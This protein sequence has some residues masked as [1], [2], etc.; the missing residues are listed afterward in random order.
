M[1]DTLAKLEASR[2]QTI[3][4]VNAMHARLREL[5]RLIGA[6]KQRIRLEEHRALAAQKQ[7]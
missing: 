3:E 4:R 7:A 5:K 6:E 2:E 1:S